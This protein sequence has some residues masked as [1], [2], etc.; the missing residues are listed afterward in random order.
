MNGGSQRKC[1]GDQIT[2]VTAVTHGGEKVILSAE[3]CDFSRRRSVF[4]EK[5]ATVVCATFEFTVQRHYADAR[6]EMRQIMA[7]RRAKFPMDRPNCGSVFVSDPATFNR[8]GP[9]GYL[10]EQ[11]G[12]KGAVAGGAQISTKHA[13]FIV[14]NGGA[15]ARDV[16]S[17]IALCIRSVRSK[18]GVTMPTEVKAVVSSC[19]VR[20]AGELALDLCD[21]L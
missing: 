13:N 21:G 11:C 7:S 2:E 12:L 8:Y 1:I 3:E 5:Q 19:R 14:N 15:T 20:N 4:Q 17:L 10:I 18:F 9:P 6:A 16:L